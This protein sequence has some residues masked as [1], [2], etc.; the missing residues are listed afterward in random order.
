MADSPPP[1]HECNTAGMGS[2]L[3]NASQASV[4]AFLEIQGKKVQGQF[5]PVTCPC[6]EVGWGIL[7]SVLGRQSKMQRM[8]L[9]LGPGAWSSPS[10]N[11]A[12]F[13]RSWLRTSLKR[14][15]HQ[16]K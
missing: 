4:K 13:R 6:L 16:T 1:Q 7:G 2:F 5:S 10:G 11:A 15:Q 3:Q 8:L 9:A 14:R 12:D